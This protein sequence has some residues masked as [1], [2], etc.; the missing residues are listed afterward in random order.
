MTG[1]LQR[2]H[3]LTGVAQSKDPLIHGDL[4]MS[5]RTRPSGWPPATRQ[6]VADWIPSPLAR[7]TVNQYEAMVDSGIFTERDRLH[8]TNGLLVAQVPKKRPHMIACD[9]ISHM[10]E[11]TITAGWHLMPDGPVRLPPGSEPQP[12]FAFVRGKPEDY[13]IRDPEPAALALVVEVSFSTLDDDRNMA[14]VYGA[15][16]IPVYWIVNLID[17]Q[18]EVYTGPDAY[19]YATYDVFKPG[20]RV[21]LFLD[22]VEVGRLAVDDMLPPPESAAESNGS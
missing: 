13:P 3:A 2:I 16:L 1:L 18:V 12:D 21:P 20:Q 11:R 10:L 19:A 14:A 5:T 4:T 9:R 8:L 22:G 7:F 17:R 6:T 15:A